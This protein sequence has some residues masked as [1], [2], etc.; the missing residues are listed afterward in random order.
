MSSVEYPLLRPVRVKSP[1]SVRSNNTILN[2]FQGIIR[3]SLELLIELSSSD[4][5][6]IQTMVETNCDT[7]EWD[8]ARILYKSKKQCHAIQ[9]T[10]KPNASCWLL[11]LENPL[12]PLLTKGRSVSIRAQQLN[13]RSFG[14]G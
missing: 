1:S 4:Y 6:G 5:E 14:F 7:S 13:S 2:N 8:I 3:E 11:G 10:H 12:L 9:N